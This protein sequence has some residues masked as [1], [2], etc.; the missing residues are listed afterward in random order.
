M[1]IVPATTG[2]SGLTYAA[3]HSSTSFAY[4]KSLGVAAKQTTV[5][6]ELLRS[7]ACV[8]SERLRGD[9][10]GV[11][12]HLS[13]CKRSGGDRDRRTLFDSTRR[14]FAGTSICW[15]VLAGGTEGVGASDSAEVGLCIDLHCPTLVR[16]CIASDNAEHVLAG[17]RVL[18]IGG[19]QV[20]GLGILAGF[21][22]VLRRRLGCL[23]G[24]RSAHLIV[25]EEV[26]RECL[27]LG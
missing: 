4:D 22:G 1:D 19:E 26:E 2:K 8:R 6:L 15:L 27:V 13:R 5:V 18:A 14:K 3:G 21:P 7:L 12:P 20:I 23:V 9:C 11:R 24:G 16:N 25:G 17:R 10:G